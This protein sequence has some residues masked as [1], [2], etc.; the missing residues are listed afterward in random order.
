MEEAKTY[1]LERK[2]TSEDI[3]I[4]SNYFKRLTLDVQISHYIN[5]ARSLGYDVAGVQYDVLRRPMHKP[6]VAKSETPDHYGERVLAAIAED[7]ERYYARRTI[8]RLQDEMVEADHDMWQTGIAIRDARRLQMFPEIRTVAC[9][10][11][12]LV[13]ISTRALGW[14]TS[15]IRCCLLSL[16]S[17]M[18]SSTPR[19]QSVIWSC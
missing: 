16:R 7:P 8:V 6:S 11:R 9:N 2:T 3:S 12:G 14:R 4:G 18:K 17:G 10:G 5:G 1:V 19:I 13:R 15:T